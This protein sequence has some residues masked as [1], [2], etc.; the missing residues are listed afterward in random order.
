MRERCGVV[1]IKKIISSF[2]MWSKKI[3]IWKIYVVISTD[4]E[5]DRTKNMN[6]DEYSENKINTDFALL[7]ESQLMK[8]P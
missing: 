8:S 5:N 3:Q 7:V 1:H 6:L 2:E 4:E